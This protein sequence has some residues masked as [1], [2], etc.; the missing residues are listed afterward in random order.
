MKQKQNIAT[1]TKVE[2]FNIIVET[3]LVDLSK[4]CQA[5]GCHLCTV[6]EKPASFTVNSSDSE[7]FK[8]G[9]SVIV[10][11]PEVNDGVAAVFTF[12]FPLI[13]TLSMMLFLSFGLKWTLESGRAVLTILITFLLSLLS[14]IVIDRILKRR[15]PIT[16]S[17]NGGC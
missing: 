3:S 16:I 9:D 13:I 10:T 8:V 14:P 2:G 15:S 11:I 5:K 17:K 4:S 7:N 1:V 6:P 12:M